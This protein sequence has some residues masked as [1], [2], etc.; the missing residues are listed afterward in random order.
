MSMI[1][2]WYH[3]QEPALEYGNQALV[4][5]RSWRIGPSGDPPATRINVRPDT[6]RSWFH[7]RC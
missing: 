6:G 4:M 1:Y 3:R 5:A 7:A 2:N